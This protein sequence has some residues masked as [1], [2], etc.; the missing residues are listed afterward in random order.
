MLQLAVVG[1]PE[2]SVKRNLQAPV[3]TSFMLP[4]R[5]VLS[6]RRWKVIRCVPPGVGSI[7]EEA[8]RKCL[9]TRG[10]VAGVVPAVTTG[11]SSPSGEVTYRS[12][13]ALPVYAMVVGSVTFQFL[14]ISKRKSS[15]P[16]AAMVRSSTIRSGQEIQKFVS[17]AVPAVSVRVMTHGPFAIA[18]PAGGW[19]RKE[20]SC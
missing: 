14:R 3:V 5:K 13:R 4:R 20:I 1:F 15:L 10:G 11:K 2:V 8:S 6:R 16:L 17:A 19:I 18:P 7:R 9:A 12:S